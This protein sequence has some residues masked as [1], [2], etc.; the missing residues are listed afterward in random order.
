[1]KTE[2]S[3]T[4]EH[5]QA[6]N[7]QSNWRWWQWLLVGG[8]VYFLSSLMQE[9]RS[10]FEK[11]SPGMS[12]AEHNRRNK[13][14]EWVELLSP[15]KQ[16][17]LM[18]ISELSDPAEQEKRLAEL[19]KSMSPAEWI[20]ILEWVESLSPESREELMGHTM[21][22]AEIKQ[23]NQWINFWES[24]SPAE[25]REYLNFWESLSEAEIRETMELNQKMG[26]IER[27]EW[28]EFWQSLSPDK[29]KKWLEVEPISESMSPA[30]QDE[31]WRKFVESLSQAEQKELMDFLKALEKLDDEI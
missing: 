12:P 6:V 31:W 23:R 11:E 22:P 28:Q 21:S 1:M 10:S 18:E 3:E 25:R 27:K 2:K 29:R 17:E 14:M 9:M 26:L 20:V 15:V 30:K 7:K 19:M 5:S 8:A 13:S 4:R 16:K 24:M